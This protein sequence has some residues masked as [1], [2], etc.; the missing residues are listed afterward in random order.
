MQRQ[1]KELQRQIHGLKKLAETT[2]PP[3]ILLTLNTSHTEAPTLGSPATRAL[4]LVTPNMQLPANPVASMPE[5][6]DTEPTWAV[7]LGPAVHLAPATQPAPASM[8]NASPLSDTNS[9]MSE[10][11]ERLCS[12][13]GQL[14]IPD[15]ASDEPTDVTMNDSPL[16][17][18]FRLSFGGATLTSGHSLSGPFTS[19]QPAH[20]SSTIAPPASN[21]WVAAQNPEVVM[22]DAPTA[23]PSATFTVAPLLNA[24]AARPATSAAAALGTFAVTTTRPSET[25]RT[26]LTITAFQFQNAPG[27]SHAP[28]RPSPLRSTVQSSDISR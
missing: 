3:P 7:Q 12:S 5:M 4:P 25:H 13:F 6:M 27:M 21:R 1:N 28:A 22:N 17:S 24:P 15:L 11:I 9:N 23:V 20:G 16:M 19:L 10:E 18:T 14:R 2:Q 8:F 26:G